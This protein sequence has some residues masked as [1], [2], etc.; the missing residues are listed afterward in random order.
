MAWI[1]SPDLGVHAS[2][3]R[4]ENLGATREGASVRHASLED[5]RETFTADLEVDRDG[6][7]RHYPGLARRVMG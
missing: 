7:V 5:G 3:Q 2:H 1:S 4:H 6:L